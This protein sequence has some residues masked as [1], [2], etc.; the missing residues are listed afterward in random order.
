[1]YVYT[2]RVARAAAILY[3]GL[4]SA[5]AARRGVMRCGTRGRGDASE[6]LHDTH[7]R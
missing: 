5:R 7:K 2:V 4:S 1:V 3:V 6:G